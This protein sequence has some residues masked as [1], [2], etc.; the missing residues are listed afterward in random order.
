M[1]LGLDEVAGSSEALDGVLEV[2]GVLLFTQ[3]G[4]SQAQREGKVPS[5]HT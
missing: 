2:A 5:I 1:H 4:E 3:P